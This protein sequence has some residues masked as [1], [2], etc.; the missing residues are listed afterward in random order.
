MKINDKEWLDRVYLGYRVYSEEIT[1][2]QNIE[3]FIKWLYTQ[4]GVVLLKQGNK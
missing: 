4:Y 3:D 2:N 1:E